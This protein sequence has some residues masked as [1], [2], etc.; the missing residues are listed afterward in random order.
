LDVV[1]NQ[2]FFSADSKLLIALA[3]ADADHQ[4]K[5][6]NLFDHHP[7]IS[8]FSQFP[9]SSHGKEFQER[10]IWFVIA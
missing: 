6:K 5:R 2:H 8:C 10:L 4:H 9:E 7:E 3:I 1:E